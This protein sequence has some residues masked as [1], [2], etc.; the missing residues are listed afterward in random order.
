MSIQAEQRNAGEL[1]V[2]Y[3]V[4]G[5][6]EF[7][8]RIQLENF[9]SNLLWVDGQDRALL[10]IK[11]TDDQSAQEYPALRR[12]LS[13]GQPD[14]AFGMGGI[15][16]LDRSIVP[17]PTFRFNVARRDDGRILAV[18]STQ[19]GE[20]AFAIYAVQYLDNGQ[21]DRSFGEQAVAKVGSFTS[22]IEAIHLQ[23]DGKVLLAGENAGHGL[24][25]RLTEVGALD[26]SW[27]NQGVQLHHFG[28]GNLVFF[29]A[30]PLDDAARGGVLVLGNDTRDNGD[31]GDMNS[32]VIARL[33][34][35]GTLDS[36]FGPEGNG[37][38]R[39]SFPT[40]D[41]GLQWIQLIVQPDDTL[42][43]TLSI[44]QAQTHM[45]I[46]QRQFTAQGIA[47]PAFNGGRPWLDFFQ[48]GQTG[49]GLKTVVTSDRKIV[50][51]GYAN[52][53]LTFNVPA[54]I[55]YLPNGQGRDT[56]FGNGGIAAVDRWPEVV[57]QAYGL[58]VQSDGKYLVLC[59]RRPGGGALFRLFP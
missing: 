15:V 37:I 45:W 2:T 54:V 14:Q 4:D 32:F 55:R 53:V 27:G 51:A 39:E 49:S 57:A 24:V 38:T 10:M 48:G 13:D 30:L 8:S 50:M 20:G 56:A 40:V 59:S 17:S 21:L 42:L 16:R 3:G 36:G 33:L 44:A 9:D 23:A 35:D 11:I 28:E 18:C 43:V 25:A 47:D 46:W 41:K 19:E 6:V 58:A 1:D 26:A 12:Y 22:P 29:Q 52:P 34:P 7:D 5:V 31:T